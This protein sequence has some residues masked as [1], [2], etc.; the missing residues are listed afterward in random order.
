MISKDHC[1]QQ[2]C[3]AWH[4]IIKAFEY[5][6]LTKVSQLAPLLAKCEIQDSNGKSTFV[7]TALTTFTV[8]FAGQATVQYQSGLDKD[9]HSGIVSLHYFLENFEFRKTNYLFLDMCKLLFFKG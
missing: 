8:T 7:S 2:V 1:A 3:L 4:T 5:K 9:F 6:T